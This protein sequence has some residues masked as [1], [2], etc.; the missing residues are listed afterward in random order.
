V[1]GGGAPELSRGDGIVVSFSPD[2]PPELAFQLADLQRT[3]PLLVLAALFGLAVVALGR[4]RG[5]LALVGVGVSLVVI[6]A[7]LLPALLDGRDPL[8]TALV[9]ASAIAFVSLFLAHGPN[10]RTAVALLGALSALALTGVLGAVF[11][12]ATRLTGLADEEATL[13][14]VAAGGIDAE[15]L[16]LAGIVIGA[17]GVLDDVTVTQV[18]ATWEL[19]R[20]APGFGPLELYRR[21]V[22]VGRD[23]IASTVN[24]LVLAYA[25]ASL[26]LL[27]LFTQAERSL[28]DVLTGEVVATEVVRTLVGSIGLVAAVPLTTALAALVIGGAGPPERAGADDPGTVPPELRRPRRRRRRDP[29]WGDLD[30][31]G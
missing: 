17:M 7:F 28:G 11:V 10:E 2:A 6:G 31:H 1:V 14:Q 8:L 4:W 20:A 3:R 23:H 27:L 9:G 21:S 18:A 22:R 12:A 5:L 15:G 25:G 16:L 24:T 19:K 29:F 13:L 26:P 30:A